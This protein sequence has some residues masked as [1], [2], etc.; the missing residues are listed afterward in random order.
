ML[1][2]IKVFHIFSVIFVHFLNFGVFGDIELNLLK[3]EFN[4]FTNNEDELIFAHTVKKK[5]INY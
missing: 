4:Q 5:Q 1:V 3:N 2:S